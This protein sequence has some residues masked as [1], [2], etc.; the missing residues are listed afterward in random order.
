SDSLPYVTYYLRGGQ[1]VLITQARDASGTYAAR[2]PSVARSYLNAD[3]LIAS[4]GR[5]AATNIAPLLAALRGLRETIAQPGRTVESMSNDTLVARPMAPYVVRGACPFECCAYGDWVIESGAELRA[6]A[7]TSAPI[8][9][10]VAPGTGVVADSGL[11]RV[12]TIGMVIVT[13]PLTTQDGLDFARGDTVL[14]LEPQG[15]GYSGAW[16][17]GRS[18]SLAQFWDSAGT[19]GARLARRPGWRWWAHLVVAQERD[20]LRGWVD[21][22]LDSLRV[23]GNDAC[24]N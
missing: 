13:A 20:T 17:R 21:M 2:P 5:P 4:T 6:T 11:V 24:G 10:R 9:G 3:T 16:I 23:S 1:P 19:T 8:V 18:L 15:E 7:S 14:L 12:D 22:Q